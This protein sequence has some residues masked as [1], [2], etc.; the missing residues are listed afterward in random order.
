MTQQRHPPR[1]FELDPEAVDAARIELVA[2]PVPGEEETESVESLPP[3]RR[4][5]WRRWFGVAASVSLLAAIVV[6]AVSWTLDLLA[7]EPLVGI[8]M[9]V[10]LAVV[11]ISTLGM[12]GIEL[13]EFLRLQKRAH[14]RAE[15]ERLMGSELH[16]GAD[17]VLLPIAREFASHHDFKLGVEAFHT[18]ASDALDDGERLVLFERHVLAPVDRHAY[19][20]VIE[21]S[22][23]VGILTALSP[24][25]LLDGLL[26]LWRT[27][28]M[29]R[30]IARLYGMAPGPVTSLAL[31]KRCLRNA[32]LA[33]LADVVAH[34]TIE[35]VG[36][37]LLTLLSARAGQGAGNALL[38]ARLGVE[39][40]RQTRPLPF[41]AERPPS[42]QEIRRRLLDAPP[43]L[44]PSA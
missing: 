39:A 14:L 20:L 30:A 42:L 43:P 22:R 18:Q 3:T 2:E 35:H 27:M 23:D 5:R 31:L 32:A 19:R 12:V 1:P 40:M 13:R 10:L 38:G 29:M 26:V 24:L 4:S 44:R 6:Q 17:P 15:A 11:A 7:R 8:P 9:A 41:I 28:I 34:A 16:G 21:S 37:S 33:G 25:G 36:A